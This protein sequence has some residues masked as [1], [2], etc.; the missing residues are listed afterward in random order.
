MK[1]YDLIVAGGGMSGVS[2]AVTAANKGLKV[3]LIEQSAILGGMGTSG[4]ITMVM[5]S[6]NWFYGLGKSLL[7]KMICEHTARYIENPLVKGFDYYPYDAEAMKRELDELILRSGIELLLCTK[8]TGLKRKGKEISELE[9]SGI[10][11]MFSAS[12]KT[13]IDATGDAC[14]CRYAEE[15]VAYGDENKNIQA[16]SLIAYY[17]G[18]DFERYEKFLATFDDGNSIP[19]IKMIHTLIPK[20]VEEKV[21]SICDFHHPG[22]FRINENSDVGVM[23]A[24]HI[25]GADCSCSK[26]ITEAIIKGRKLA[27]EYLDFY[28]KY[29]PGFEHAYMTNTGSQ[30]ALRETF[31]LEGQYVTT[32]KDKAQYTKFPDAIMRFDGGATSDLH[33]SSASEKDYNAYL[34]LFS[35]REGIRTD[36]YATLPFR[37]LKCVRTSNLIAA[38]RCVSADRETLGQIRIMGYCF[39]MGEAAGIAAYLAVKNDNNFDQISLTMLQQE[40]LNLGIETI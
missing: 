26:G 33:A 16:P 36:D 13:F 22:I 18:I 29:I 12:A 5:T 19:K 38:G 30:L 14:L 37:S 24:G 11:G 2:A 40:L 1:T 10:E 8:I 6:K 4:L 20:A 7:K 17:S 15:K 27:K 21:V 31:R 28:K 34:K 25:Y 9:L 23:N 35:K 32:F 39:M 3:L